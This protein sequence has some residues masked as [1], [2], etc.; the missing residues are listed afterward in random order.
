MLAKNG[1]ADIKIDKTNHQNS[2]FTDFSRNLRILE[3]P[4]GN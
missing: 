1:E 3:T 4:I 2:I